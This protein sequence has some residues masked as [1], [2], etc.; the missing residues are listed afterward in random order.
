MKDLI[1]EMKS[2]LGN[3][4]YDDIKSDDLTDNKVKTSLLSAQSKFPEPSETNCNILFICTTTSEMIAYWR[5]I[6]NAQSGFFHEKSN[7]SCFLKKKM[8]FR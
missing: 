7:V 2:G 1:E 8:E 4:P 6:V 5:Y 3:T